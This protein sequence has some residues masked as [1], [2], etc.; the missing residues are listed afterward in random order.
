LC[1]PYPTGDDRGAGARSLG[2]RRRTAGRI[3]PGGGQGPVEYFFFCQRL[4]N[5]ECIFTHNDFLEKLLVMLTGDDC[6]LNYFINAP[7][8]VDDRYPLYNTTMNDGKLKDVLS[9]LRIG[10]SEILRGQ[11]VGV[12]LYGSQ[13]RG[14]AHFDSDIDVIIILRDDF[15][16]SEMLDKTVDLVAD[17]S[18]EF[19][20]VI[21]RA[22]V[23]KDRYEHEMSPFYMN[24]RREAVPV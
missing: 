9:K 11:L 6:K 5:S 19:D 22:F 13:A 24:V 4:L 14:E 23:S 8:L 2:N 16:Y 7:L 10:L 3:L 1:N 15:D 12:Y 18:L 20:V 21:S 17:L